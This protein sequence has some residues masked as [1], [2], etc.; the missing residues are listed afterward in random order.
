LQR[1]FCDN[2]LLISENRYNFANIRT[3]YSL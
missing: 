3:N 1:F 2:N